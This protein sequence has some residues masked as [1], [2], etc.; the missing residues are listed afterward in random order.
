VAPNKPCQVGVAIEDQRIVIELTGCKQGVPTR[1]IVTVSGVRCGR[2]D[3]RFPVFSA[4]A[5]QKNNEF[6]GQALPHR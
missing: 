3:K 2:Q 1:L 4:E 5:A 6:W